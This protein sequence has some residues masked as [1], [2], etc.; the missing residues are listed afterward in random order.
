MSQRRE[1]SRAIRLIPTAV[2][3]ALLATVTAIVPAEAASPAAGQGTVN[4]ATTDSGTQEQLT[5]HATSG[6]DRPAAQ[7][8][9]KQALTSGAQTCTAPN[10]EGT[11]VCVQETRPAD[12]PARLAHSSLAAEAVDPPQWCEDA[13]G[14]ILGT[15]TQIC[16]V[17]GLTYTTTRTVNGTTTVT[18]EADMVVIN[19]SYSDTGLPTFAHQ[20]ELS[21][22]D[23]WGDALNASVDGQ[24]TLSGACTLDSS[25]FPAQPLLPFNSWRSGEAFFDTTATAAGAIGTCAT[26]WYLTFTNAGYPAAVTDFQLNEFRCDNA[27]VGRANVGCVV[28]WY[29]SELVYGSASYPSLASHVQQAQASGLPGATFANPLTRT[30]DDTIIRTNR[31]LACGDA[32]SITGLSCDEYPIAR[33]REGL[34]SGGTRRTFDGCQMPNVSSGTGPTGVSV[35]MITATENNAQGGLNTQF[36]RAERVLDGDPFRVTVS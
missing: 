8:E 21:M 9:Q 7:P 3:A 4:Q 5:S 18:G 13:N 23:G 1:R 25:S 33:S 35:C 28:P 16:L 20:I 27:T 12:L 30:E 11:A 2:V 17:T 6:S 31:N 10:A 19:Y 36:F 15:R 24:A 32:P 29:A 22:Y 26:F 34:S 14:I